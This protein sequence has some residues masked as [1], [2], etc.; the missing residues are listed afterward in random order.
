MADEQNK[1]LKSD[2]TRLDVTNLFGPGAIEPIDSLSG[3]PLGTA[4]D[5]ETGEIVLKVMIVA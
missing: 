3:L 2:N 4:D 5:T 1:I